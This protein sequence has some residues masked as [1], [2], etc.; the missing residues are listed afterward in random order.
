MHGT[1]NDQ[2]DARNWEILQRLQTAPKQSV[3][4]TSRRHRLL[5]SPE[6]CSLAWSPQSHAGS[7]LSNPEHLDQAGQAAHLCLSSKGLGDIPQIAV[8]K[9]SNPMT[10]TI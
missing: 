5:Q 10:E 8:L 6:G 3:H 9:T 7:R 1:G 2:E 4:V